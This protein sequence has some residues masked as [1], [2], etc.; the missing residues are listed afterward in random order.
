MKKIMCV[1][2]SLFFLSGCFSSEKLT[3]EPIKITAKEVV[4]RL[5]NQ[6]TDTFLLYITTNSCYSCDEYKKVIEKLKKIKSFD[7]YELTIDQDEDDYD[8]KEALGELEVSIGE[9]KTFPMTYYFYKGN[10]QPENV[11]EGYIEEK[12]FKAWLENLHI[13]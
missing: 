2:L 8:V 10:L 6:K 5:Q 4:E 13:L 7:I 11:K 12:D 3:N 9:Y 1:I